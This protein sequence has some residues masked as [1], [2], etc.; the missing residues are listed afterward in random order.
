M[1]EKQKR[2]PLSALNLT[3]HWTYL[4]TASMLTLAPM[5]AAAGN[6]ESKSENTVQAVQQAKKTVT[7]KVT[8]PTGEPVIGATVAEAGNAKNAV[9]TD[10][11]GDYKLQIK[12]GAKVTVTFVGFTPDRGRER[13][14]RQ[15]AA[16]RGQRDPGRVSGCG[17]RYAEEERPDRLHDRR[18]GREH[19]RAEHHHRVACP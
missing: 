4:L 17:L 7:G 10:V 3:K 1:D 5:G 8:D 15:R 18:Q 6:V 12:P 16:G 11:N 19:S 14:Y 9:I 2:N 13:R